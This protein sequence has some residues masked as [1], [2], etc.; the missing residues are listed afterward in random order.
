MPRIGP[1]R[2][3]P[4]ADCVQLCK[5]EFVFTP[6][7]AK[8][9][10]T[11]LPWAELVAGLIKRAVGGVKVAHRVW[12]VACVWL[13]AV[14]WIT[15]LAWRLAFLR[16]FDEVPRLLRERWNVLAIATDCIQ[17]GGR[18]SA[19]AVQHSSG[20]VLGPMWPCMWPRRQLRSCKKTVCQL[21]CDKH[22]CER[23]DCLHEASASRASWASTT[24][25]GCR[26]CCR[27]RCCPSPLCLSTCQCSV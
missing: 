19:G 9:A 23:K 12:V 27:V 25:D 18:S 22:H 17:V 4:C 7:Y 20:E 21:L 15:C 26:C 24:V 11:R 8:D 14:P 5:H 1:D 10:P 2:R 16:G 3:L 6:V 13:I